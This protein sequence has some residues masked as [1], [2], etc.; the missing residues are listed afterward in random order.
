MAQL[1]LIIYDYYNCGS[2][3]R[4]CE[5]PYKMI[6]ENQRSSCLYEKPHKMWCCLPHTAYVCTNKR[7]NYPS[8]A[9]PRC[10]CTKNRT[11]AEIRS[12]VAV[13]RPY[14]VQV[15]AAEPVVCE[16]AKRWPLCTDFY[17]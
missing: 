16:E 6:G 5:I 17:L 13:I 14:N 2:W 1:L 3:L 12:D 9:S 8:P 4:L 15:I 11:N 10:V 7:T